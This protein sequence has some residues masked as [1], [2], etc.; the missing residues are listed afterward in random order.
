M[1]NVGLQDEGKPN[2]PLSE[3]QHC[4]GV[5][6]KDRDPNHINDHVKVRFSDVFAE[7]DEEV[8]SFERIWVLN[9]K[10]FTATKLWCYRIL[11]LILALPCAVCW[12]LNFACLAF[13]NIWCCMPCL[14]CYEVDM[15]CFRRS[16]EILLGSYVAPCCDVFSRCLGGIKVKVAKEVV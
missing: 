14:R 2:S 7:P 12:G 15:T 5:D 6:C 11:S 10:I 9:Y 16:W 1:M 8:Y 3:E 4:P 13:C